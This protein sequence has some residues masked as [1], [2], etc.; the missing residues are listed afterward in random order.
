VLSSTICGATLAE[1]NYFLSAMILI[2]TILLAVI[3]SVI[4]ASY[5]KRK[6]KIK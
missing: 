3:G 2:V 6:N 1:K 5:I 4:Y